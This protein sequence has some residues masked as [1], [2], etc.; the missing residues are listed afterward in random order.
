MT[1]HST[2]KIILASTSPRRK[3]ILQLLQ[4]PFEVI[5]PNYEEES[6]N[7][8]SPYEEAQRFSIEKAN[9]LQ[10]LYP[11]SIIIGS[12]TLIEFE[13]Q[14][15]GKPR[16][17]EHAK[18]ILQKLR[19]KTHDVLSAV[20]ILDTE[21]QKMERTVEVT[22]ITMNSYC[23]SEIEAYIATKE[24]LDKAGSY[25]LQGHGRFLISK[26]EGDYLSAVGLPLRFV[27]ESLIKF[28][29]QIPVDVEKIYQEKNFLNWKSYKPS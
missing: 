16:N 12:D 19:G 10:T 26:L 1:K 13:G 3:E 14:K 29:I 24:P 5:P 2:P 11:D 27:A 17:P 8:L 20:C 23:D 15:I 21:N 18:E 7:E 25:A 28:G 9:S 4:I 6:L 22:Q